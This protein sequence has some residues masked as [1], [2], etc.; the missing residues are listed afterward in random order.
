MFCILYL[1]W[2]II[3]AI[4]PCHRGVFFRLNVSFSPRP[5]YILDTYSSSFTFLVV[6]T[7]NW[8][9]DTWPLVNSNCICIKKKWTLAL[10]VCANAFSN[11]LFGISGETLI[12]Y[13]LLASLLCVARSWVL[14]CYVRIRERSGRGLLCYSF[15]G[16][17]KDARSFAMVGLRAD[18][19]SAG[20]LN[21][22]Q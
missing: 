15:G 4:F 10:R 1:N 8:T 16:N 12:C 9:A 7:W 6:K 14:E 17:G 22:T 2:S 5:F 21:V 18:I 13:G 11:F 19:L 3:T 20:I